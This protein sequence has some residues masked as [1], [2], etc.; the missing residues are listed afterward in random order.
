MQTY[1][2]FQKLNWMINFHQVNLKYVNLVCL[3]DLTEIQL[4]I[5]DD[6]PA[7]LLQHD[8][9]TN[10]ENLSVGINL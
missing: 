4:Y 2:S 1:Y 6:I 3:I 10:I 7:T 9:G 8:F 5:R